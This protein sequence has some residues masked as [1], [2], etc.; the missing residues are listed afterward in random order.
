VLEG[1]LRAAAVR[2]QAW[3]CNLA[4]KEMAAALPWKGAGEGPGEP[5]GRGGSGEREDDEAQAEAKIPR[6]RS[7]RPCVG[8]TFAP[9]CA[10]EV[11]E[12][13]AKLRQ[14]PREV[15]RERAARIGRQGAADE[16]SSRLGKKGRE[17]EWEG[18]GTRVGRQGACW[19][20][21][22]PKV[23]ADTTAH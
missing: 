14:M 8:G 6:R 19:W 23:D 21:S 10:G 11:L 16:R 18:G 15:G 22:G 17:K 12:D 9:P 3:N 1:A 4:M 20:K 5:A 13:A 7:A 2:G